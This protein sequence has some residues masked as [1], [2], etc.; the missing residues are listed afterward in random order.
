MKDIKNKVTVG[1]ELKINLRKKNEVWQVEKITLP[2]KKPAE[3]EDLIKL[4]QNLGKISVFM[5]SLNFAALFY[6][7]SAIKSVRNKI[8][9]R[10]MRGRIQISIKNF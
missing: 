2:F 6:R 1:D 9:G 3:T 7:C 4:E 5:D 8:K 10:K